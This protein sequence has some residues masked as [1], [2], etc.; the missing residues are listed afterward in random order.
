MFDRREI[1]TIAESILIAALFMTEGCGRAP[2]REVDFE[3]VRAEILAI[4]NGL[5]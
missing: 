4:E 5:F 3:A 2:K 1:S